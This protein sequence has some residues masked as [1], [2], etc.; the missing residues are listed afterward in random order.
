M[1]IALIHLCSLMRRRWLAWGLALAVV[2]PGIPSGVAAAEV[3]PVEVVVQFRHNLTLYRF[4]FAPDVDVAAV[5][6]RYRA[7]PAV[8]YAEPNAR[9]R[10][11]AFPSDPNFTRQWYLGAIRARD[12]WSSELVVAE[13]RAVKTP[14]IA[15]LDSGVDT[16]HPDLRDKIW[17]NAGER[18]NDGVD[19]DGN[20]F[21]DD[22]NGWDFVLD[23]PNPN[24]KPAPTFDALAQ[25]HGTIVAGLAAASSHNAQGIAGVSWRARILP[26]RV[27]DAEGNGTVYTVT[28]AIQYATRLRVDVINLS[29]VGPERSELLTEA[30]KAAA[31]AGVVVVAAAGNSAAGNGATNL[32][33]S[34]RYPVCDDAD[35]DTS[36]ILGVA[37][38][39]RKLARP[40]FT[41]YGSRC[42]DLAAPGE[43]I[44][45]TIAS[46]VAPADTD[47]GYADHLGN[48]VFSGTSLAA[49]LVAGAAAVVKSLRPDLGAAQVIAVL[50]ASA[51]DLTPTAGAGSGLGAGLLDS[52]ASVTRALA[53]PVGAGPEAAREQAFLV[54]A[55]GFGSF[56]QIK[57]LRPDGSPYKSFFAYAPTFSGLIHL[58]VA[59]VNGD[60]ADDVVTGTGRGGGPQV[61]VFTTEGKLLGQFFA[62]D[63]RMRNGVAVAAGD[64][65]GDG[66]A[67]IVTSSNPG[68]PPRVR[69]WRADGTPLASFDAYAPS[70][71]GGVQAAVGDLDGDGHAEIVVAPG[72]GG[73]PH[74]RVFSGSGQLLGQFFAYNEL[75]RTGVAVAATDLDADGRAEIVTAT[76][77]S[78]SPTVKVFS[79]AAPAALR[80]EFVLSTEGDW[81]SGITVAAGDLDR[82]G[83]GELIFGRRDGAPDVTVVSGQG[84]ALRTFSAHGATSYRGGVRVGYLRLRPAVR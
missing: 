73:G 75:A 7:H 27:L 59:D 32:D 54:A 9:F 19:N 40:A 48:R 34:R 42:V 17:R 47:P 49:P 4:R 3:A 28:R 63:R 77:S 76:L 13:S 57:I 62:E 21:S 14:V 37:A 44:F 38:V 64:L 45:S 78:A 15:I 12:A 72:P 84:K 5:V 79:R 61:R 60:G 33:A 55:L 18:P 67:E 81:S 83:T 56:P 24:P 10:A 52:A 8:A 80:S 71:R 30:L 11:V 16:A 46:T 82:D 2:L 53:L 43:A 22:I 36:Y 65:D 58:A 41:N 23:V 74:V 51:V 70:F 68:S 69:V 29:F 26:L 1:S 66:R 6:Q 50:K 35:S 25:T 39:D 20:G 31:S